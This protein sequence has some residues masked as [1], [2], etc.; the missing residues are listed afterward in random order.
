M[1]VAGLQLGSS[2][3]QALCEGGEREREEKEKTR[4]IRRHFN[5]L[6]SDAGEGKQGWSEA[7]PV[8]DKETGRG[9]KHS[10]ESRLKVFLQLFSMEKC[11]KKKKNRERNCDDRLNCW[12]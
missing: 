9:L 12:D 8:E 3:S 4:I 7:L 10:F 5:L 11:L 6:W 2:D 1:T